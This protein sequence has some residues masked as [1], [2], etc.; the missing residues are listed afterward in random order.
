M[1][2][3]KVAMAA[4]AKVNQEAFN[5]L[6]VERPASEGVREPGLELAEPSPG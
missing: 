2:A 4:L 3:R 1:S 6:P 5:R